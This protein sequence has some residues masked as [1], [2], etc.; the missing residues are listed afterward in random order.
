MQIAAQHGE[1][2]ADKA[3]RARQADIGQREHHETSGI[4]GHAIDQRVNKYL[5]N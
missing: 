3:R 5:Q 1:E 2:F 4:H